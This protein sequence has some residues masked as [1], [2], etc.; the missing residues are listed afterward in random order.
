MK[1]L[2]LIP[3]LNEV[4]NIEPL[5]NGINRYNP[6]IDIFIIDGGSTDGTFEAVMELNKVFPNVRIIRNENKRGFGGA[7]ACGFN[8]AMEGAYDPV[9]TMDGDL[10]HNP[11]YLNDILEKSASYDLVIGSRYLNGVRV[12]G[13][14]FRKLFFSKLANMF[15]SYLMVKPI[16]DFT[17]GFRCYRRCILDKINFS[18][19]NAI[20]Y[21]AQIQLLS[22]TFHH[23]FRVKEIPFI[24]RELRG[25]VS[26]IGKTPKYK[27]LYYLLK[28]RAPFFE[29]LRHLTYLKKD[30]RKFVEEYDEFV[31]P[32]KLK[33]QKP[34]I[35][36]RSLSV[37]VGVMAYNEED[38]IGECIDSLISQKPGTYKIEEIIVVSS[39]STDSTNDIVREFS[40]KDSRVRLLVQPVRMGKASAINEFLRVARGDI[41]VLESA[42]T[43]AEP[44]TVNELIKPFENPLTGMT[45]AHPLPINKNTGFVGFC[46]NKLWQLHH[47]IALDSPK[48]GEMIAFRNIIPKIPRYTA[49]DEAAIEA[50]LA[51]EGYKI[52]YADKAIVHNKGPETIEDFIKQRRRIAAGHK[53]LMSAMRY[54]VATSNSCSILKYVFKYQKWTPGETVFMMF[55]LIIESYSRLLGM[56]DY[57]LKDKNPFM[58]DIAT[59]TK[60]WI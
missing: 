6:D 5:I 27:T 47:F 15:I 26:K 53:H 37:S 10:S 56:F 25:Q 51:S 8:K 32:P 28:Y 30:Y 11:E 40:H 33:E 7:L 36:G 54:R 18:E 55:L 48:C 39:G 42:D 20:G 23:R 57:Y 21:I 31:N 45:G 13:W 38:I 3:T 22:L 58:W 44:D 12:E 4:K 50:I 59:T 19:I 60:R 34:C 41:A 14:R 1:P 16:W 49:V 2:I 9:I 46:V 29:I 43:V 35:P 17:S 52:I 24:F